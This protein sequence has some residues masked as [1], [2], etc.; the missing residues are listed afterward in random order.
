MEIFNE[1]LLKDDISK[2][3]VITLYLTT[4]GNERLKPKLREETKEGTRVVSRSFKISGWYPSKTENYDYAKLFLSARWFK[5]NH[6]II[7]HFYGVDV[8]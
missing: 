6:T 7:N 1:D 3:T 5:P 2:A 4:S 8:V